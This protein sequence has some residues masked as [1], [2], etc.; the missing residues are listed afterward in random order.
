MR[1]GDLVVPNL[2]LERLLSEGGMGSVWVAD[3]LTLSTQVA[4]KFMGADVAADPD[5]LARFKREA[6]AA[7]QV[8]SPH[9][10]Q[11]FDHGVTGEGIPYIVMELLNGED[12]H[13]R[14]ARGPLSVSDTLVVMRHL[15]KALGRAHQQG[16]VHRDIKPANLFL[17]DIDGDLFVKVLDFGIAKQSLEDDLTAHRTRSG[18]MVG[19]PTYMSPEQIMGQRGLDSRADLWAAAV[20]AYACLTAEVPFEGNTIGALAVTINA[21]RFVPVTQRVPD[22][23]PALDA[24]FARALSRSPDDR[25]QS[26]K[27]GSE[28]FAAAVPKELHSVRPPGAPG[29]EIPV[30]PRNDLPTLDIRSG[31]RVQKPEASTV[32]TSAANVGQPAGRIRA[33]DAIAEE[34]R[35][36]SRLTLPLAVGAIALMVGGGAAWV[37]TAH[38]PPSAAGPA[39][40]TPVA[41]H[42]VPDPSSAPASVPSASPPATSASTAEARPEP[43]ASVADTGPALAS[44]APS[45]SAVASAGAT[46]SAAGAV[47]R[48]ASSPRTTR[49]AE[50]AEPSSPRVPFGVLAVPELPQIATPHGDAGS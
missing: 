49:R 22:L 41:A 35:H 19:T 9:I 27:E 12:L 47:A 42:A 6:S 21:A 28:A 33:L 20:V 11:V 39:L 44:P 8:K 15:F 5:A 36:R 29:S 14:L 38:P 45:G 23:P 25:F 31:A 3:H 43:D 16:I 48:P 17:L 10:V 4:V 46:S 30:V 1:P 18:T 50:G 40:S 24:W 34:P 37:A 2:R 32:V 26:A 7:A 13:H